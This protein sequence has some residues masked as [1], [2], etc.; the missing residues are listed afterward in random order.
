[1][2]QT[3]DVTPVVRAFSRPDLKPTVEMMAR[4]FDDDPVMTWIFPDEQMRRRRLPRF[5]AASMHGT[6]MKHD[7]SEIVVVGDEIVGCAT[8]M[9]PE[10]WMPS[11]WQQMVSLPGY[12]RTLG[13]RLGIASMTYSAML[14]VHPRAPHWYLAGIGTEPRLQGTGIGSRLMQARLAR[15]DAAGA[16]AY[17]ESSKESNVGFYERRGFTVT[18]ELTIA[19]GGPTLWLMWR[20]PQRLDSGGTTL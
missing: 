17:L 1:V 19:G 9:P 8:W 3:S 5:F 20:D 15:C 4:A 14:S 11:F 13:S 16:A 12:A 6:G 2:A 18:R 10:T 7:G